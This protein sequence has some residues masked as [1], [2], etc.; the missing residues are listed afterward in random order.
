MAAYQVI[1]QPVGRVDGLAKTTGQARYAV[2]LL[3]PGA[4]WGKSLHSPYSHALIVR[5]DTTA[6]CHVPGVH[7]VIT[8]AD[9]RGGLWGRAVKDVPVLAYDRVRFAGEH[10]AAVAAAE[11]DIAQRAL[12][13]IEVEYEVLP[14]VLDAHAALQPEAPI[15]RPDYKIQCVR[16]RLLHGNTLS[17]VEQ[18]H[19]HQMHSTPLPG[20]YGGGSLRRQTGCEI[21]GPLACRLSRGSVD[22]LAGLALLLQ[23]LAP[24]RE[25]HL[26]HPA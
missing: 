21:S 24:A 14:A 22:G 4:L 18:V 15:L 13:L 6:A 8:G 19:L 5:I 20:L 16:K 2:D 7:A 12:D 9:V 26:T 1:G 10:V 11:E 17:R 25:E 23:N 3:L